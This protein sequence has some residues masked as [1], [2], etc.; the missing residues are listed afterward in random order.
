MKTIVQESDNKKTLRRIT[1]TDFG[2]NFTYRG[3]QLF[4]IKHFISSFYIKKAG[5]RRPETCFFLFFG[6]PC[7]LPSGAFV[8][9]HTVGKVCLL[10][11]TQG[12]IN[13]SN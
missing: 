2:A 3:G 9:F 10:P 13:E 7:G 6:A 11:D 4:V 12:N 1:A 5:F 8:P